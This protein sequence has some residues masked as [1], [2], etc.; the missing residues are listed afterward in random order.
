MCS[1]TLR[2]VPRRI[3]HSAEYR[4]AWFSALMQRHILKQLSKTLFSY[5][6]SAYNTA[7]SCVRTWTELCGPTMQ[8]NFTSF[9]GFTA[10]AWLPIMH[11]FWRRNSGMHI[12]KNAK[13]SCLTQSLLLPPQCK[14]A[15]TSWYRHFNGQRVP[16]DWLRSIAQCIPL[17]TF[18]GV[19]CNV[20]TVS[21]MRP[22]GEA[23]INALI[24][25]DHVYIANML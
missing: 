25:A 13:W 21:K 2:R 3:K 16:R 15:C 8:C 14:R 19:A 20:H 1:C 7:L 24:H 11:T 10:Q 23:P 6:E 12:W 5:L 9:H 17:N 22:K 4:I 18:M